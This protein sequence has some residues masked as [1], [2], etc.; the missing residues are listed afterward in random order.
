MR[1]PTYIGHDLDETTQLYIDVYVALEILHMRYPDYMRQTSP[2][3]RRL[4]QLF[5]AMK[6]QKE[7]HAQWHAEHDQKASQIAREAVN[8]NARA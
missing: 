7:K 6:G 1:V 8:I 5:L 3:E 4:Y 2:L